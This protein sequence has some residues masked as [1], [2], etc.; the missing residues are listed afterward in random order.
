MSKIAA[1]PISN[2]FRQVLFGSL[3]LAGIAFCP[4]LGAE[5]RARPDFAPNA[6]VGWVTLS[7]QGQFISPPSGPG[8]VKGDPLHSGGT[9]DDFR[10]TGRQPTFPVADLANPIL[11]P[12][13]REKL[14][15]H[16]E[17]VLAGKPA[18]TRRANCWPMG[19]PGFLLYPVQPVYFIQ[20]PKKVVMVWQLDHQV[21]HVYLDVPHS[22][23]PK[24]SWFGE[25]IGHYEGDTL[26]VDTI[27]IDTRTF[28][29]DFE[30]PHSD[31]L[32]V[33]ER[34]RM[35]DGG[36]TLEV[37]VRVDDSGAFTMPWNAIQRYRRV[38]PGKA[39]NPDRVDD[40]ASSST[41]AGPL[42]ESTCAENPVS[43]FGS[44]AQ[45][46]PRADKPDF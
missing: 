20:S 29:D 13:V 17:R 31:K 25:S 7:P 44:E 11:Q 8:P 23:N 46:I 3:F 41:V 10:A 34:F 14:K 45:A 32:H 24:P 6:S 2:R 15:E 26:V 21:R 40:G 1:I 27:G 5:T 43:H 30:T 19:V 16:N 22:N 18:F 12:W 42:L 35:I 9:N 36:M 38:E 33:V 39:E 37:N 4:A 28:V